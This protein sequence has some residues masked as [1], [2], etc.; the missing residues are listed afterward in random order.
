MVWRIVLIEDQ[1]GESLGEAI[2]EV[3][4]G[5]LDVIPLLPPEDISLTDVL[6]T[7][8]DLY[9]VD[10]ELDTQQENNVI[11]SYRGTT[12]AARL[13][14]IRSEYPIVLF[15]RSDL[16]IWASNQRI[17]QTERIFD[18]VLYKDKDLGDVL[19]RARTVLLSS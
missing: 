9:L 3:G 16:S 13:R 6:D 19:G 11:A 4:A 17:V 8:A 2:R 12:L 14:E 5:D 10:Y 7:E 18:D 15:T 1:D